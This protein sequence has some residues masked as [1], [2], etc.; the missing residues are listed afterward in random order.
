M[1]DT[2]KGRDTGRRRSRLHAGSPMWD[3]IPGPGTCPEP[4]ADTQPL[5]HPGIPQTAPNRHTHT[6]IC[7]NTD[8]Y[9]HEEIFITSPLPRAK[10]Y[11]HTLLLCYGLTCHFQVS[12]GLSNCVFKH[13]VSRFTNTTTSTGNLGELLNL[14]VGCENPLKRICYHNWLI[15]LKD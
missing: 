8:I 6:V 11:F 2:E 7:T 12:H 9:T 14:F 13:T 10:E 4:K 1:R 15:F 3:S 5:S